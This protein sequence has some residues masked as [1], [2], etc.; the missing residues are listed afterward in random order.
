MIE[1]QVGNQDMTQSI[2]AI[3]G[4]IISLAG[5][6]AVKSQQKEDTE[7]YRLEKLT[8]TELD[9]VVADVPIKAEGKVDP[10]KIIK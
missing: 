4:V 3:G 1:K 2:I 7:L 5:Y 9:D 6:L 8:S 10:I